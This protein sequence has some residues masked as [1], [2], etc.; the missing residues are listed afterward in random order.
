MPLR[1]RNRGLFRAGA[2][3]FR[4]ATAFTQTLTYVYTGA[5][6][7]WIVPPGVTSINVDLAGAE[8]YPSGASAGQGARVQATYPVTPGQTLNLYVGGAGGSGGAFG[9][10]GNPGG[11]FNGG[12]GGGNHSG[13]GGDGNAAGG[14]GGATDIRIGGTA[15]ADRKLIAGGGGGRS[16]G[17]GGGNG[18]DGGGLTGENGT[19]GGANPQIGLGG[20]PTAGG[21][22]INPGSLGQGGVGTGGSTTAGGGGGGGL[23]G[24][25]GGGVTGAGGGGTGGGGGG[26]SYTDPSASG[27]THTRGFRSGNGYITISYS[28]T[29]A[30]SYADPFNRPNNSSMG[31]DWYEL[32]SAYEINN[33]VLICPSGSANVALWAATTPVNDYFGQ[34]TIVTK[35]IN[36]GANQSLVMRSSNNSF[37]GDWYTVGATGGSISI[38]RR[39]GGTTTTIATA[40]V[41]FA[42]GDVLKATCVG[43]V[44]TGYKNGT[45]AVTFTDT[46]QAVWSGPYTGIYTVSPFGWAAY[47]NWS[48]GN[49]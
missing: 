38:I 49:V 10:G 20:T 19:S 6:Q 24:G 35:D 27:V 3:P 36:A 22:A 12:G 48:A 29:G 40:A 4:I 11:G 43:N 34:M 1:S 39:F 46:A 31:A 5:A 41:G 33:N 16:V 26:S 14:G 8:G 17:F 21:A 30:F 9:G 45:Q 37:T 15:L 42:D 13:G 18:G 7:S 25:G 28:T 2:G 44:I 47:D 23:Y 32:G